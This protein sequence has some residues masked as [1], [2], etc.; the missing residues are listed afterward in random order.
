MGILSVCK[1][2]KADC[3]IPFPERPLDVGIDVAMEFKDDGA[4]PGSELGE[5][6]SSEPS[7]SSP[8]KSSSSSPER[9][10]LDSA[11]SLRSCVRL[12]L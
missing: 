11:P 3:V 9:G 12:C 2:L 5:A 8:E 6:S 4:Y 10:R 1:V 7:W